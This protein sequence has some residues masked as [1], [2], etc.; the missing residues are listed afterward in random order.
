MT[1]TIPVAH[2]FI[3]PWCWVGLFQARKLQKE[4]G[5][6]IEWLGYELYPEEIAWPEKSHK[7]PPPANKPKTP[8]RFELL[9]WAEQ[10]ELPDVV[11]PKH[12]RTHNAHEAVEYAKIEGTAD[13][14]VEALYRAYWEQGLEINN[15]DVIQKIAEPI[16]HDIE[17]LMCAVELKRFKSRIVG[18]DDAAYAR[19]VYNV[20]TFFIGGERIAEHPYPY[21]RKKVLEALESTGAES[22]YQSLD[23]PAAPADRPYVYLNMIATIDGKTV[24][25]SRDESVADLGSKIDHTL[26]KRIEASADAVMLGAQTLR[27]TSK[28]WNPKSHTR[29]VVTQSGEVPAESAF[30]SDGEAFLATG[31]SATVHPPHGVKLLRTGNR[32]VDIVAL[33]ERLRNRGV[34]RLLC[35]GGSE[36][37][38]QLLRLGLVDELFLTIAPKVKLGKC[39]P[40]YAG[41]EP[42]DRAELLGFHLVENHAVGDEVFLRYR[43]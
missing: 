3:C 18:F 11:R 42:L 26:M 38:A 23:F 13:R 25:G 15:P 22:I 14:L 36:L 21:L 16:V 34:E 32:A 41:G 37:N 8:G 5:A 24:S 17:A 27:V 30:L 4:F 40:T 1:L 20:P 6:K 9:L 35:L 10:M 33:L 12:M 2:D 31:G 28:K 39:L 29:I 7:T 43:R 19:G